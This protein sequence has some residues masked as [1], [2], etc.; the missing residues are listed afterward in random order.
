ML[1]ST[2]VKRLI[3][4]DLIQRREKR[5]AEYTPSGKLSASILYWPTRWQLFKNLGI[6]QREKDAYTL[7]VFDKGNEVENKF[8]EY[9]NKFGLLAEGYPG[10]TWNEE[11]KQWQVE[12][13]DA[14][15]MIDALV[16]TDRFDDIKVG[17]IPFEVKSVTA[18]KLSRLK[19]NGELDWQWK[20]QAGFYA[21]AMGVDHYGLA[22]ISKEHDFPQTYILETRHIRPEIEKIIDRYRQAVE[23]WEKLGE[24]PP[25]EIPE[26]VRWLENPKYAP[27]DEKWNDD[28]MVKSY[29]KEVN[30]D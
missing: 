14:V 19:K 22:I 15:G 3:E 25:L 9:L 18:A 11:K 1:V 29:L 2:Y 26:Q 20:L 30:H 17:I 10:L 8:V 16:D 5:D 23:R 21:T 27:F 4:D 28:E 13:R 7:G 24:L 12:Y 6:P